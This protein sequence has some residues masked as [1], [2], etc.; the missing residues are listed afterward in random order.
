M[1][2]N[3][4]LYETGVIHGRF[5]V[6]HNDHVKY[7]MAGKELCHNLVIGIT[8]PDMMATGFEKSDPKRNKT[9][10]NPLTYYE[11]YIIIKNMMLEKCVDLKQ[12]TIVPFPINY[13][14]RYKQYLPMDGVF[15]LT[16]YDDWG[17]Q[18]LK[19]FKSLN[20]KYHVLWDIAYEEKGISS[21]DIRSA[22]LNSQKWQDKVPES[23]K[24]L[25]VKWDIVQRLKQMAL[26]I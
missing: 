11:R 18:K 26:L 21:T 13:P 20:L 17:R 5:Q 3:S 9:L 4:I 14:D 7:I 16:I 10:A 6:L 19:Y 2:E 15:F 12:V 1:A 24:Q 8:N 25:L 22:M 23:T